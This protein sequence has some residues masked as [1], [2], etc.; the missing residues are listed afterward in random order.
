MVQLRKVDDSSLSLADRAELRKAEAGLQEVCL[1]A[2]SPGGF[3]ARSRELACERQRRAS[4]ARRPG[5]P[6]GSC[7]SSLA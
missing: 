7:R 2:V 1:N 5:I 3:A 6:P 4:L